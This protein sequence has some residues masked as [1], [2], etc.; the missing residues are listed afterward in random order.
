[1]ATPR[2]IEG[3]SNS[4]RSVVEGKPA[5]SSVHVAPA[6]A[7]PEHP[8]RLEARGIQHARSP[9][10]EPNVCQRDRTR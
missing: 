2:R 10:I 6:S 4:R 8:A 7:V 3:E 1:M 9:R 5:V